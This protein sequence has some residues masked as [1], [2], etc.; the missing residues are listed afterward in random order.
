MLLLQMVVL[1]DDGDKTDVLRQRRGG[2]RQCVYDSVFGEDSTQA[3]EKLE[4]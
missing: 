3:S 4:R 1:E 2:E